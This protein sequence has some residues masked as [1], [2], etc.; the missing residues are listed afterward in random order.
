M[1][2]TLRHY[3]S[4]LSLWLPLA[5]TFQSNAVSKYHNSGTVL[6]SPQ[7]SC[8]TFSFPQTQSSEGGNPSPYQSPYCE[9]P[10]PASQEGHF[11]LSA[12]PQLIPQRTATRSTG[13]LRRQQPQRLWNSPWWGKNDISR[14]P[15]HVLPP[16]HHLNTPLQR[17]SRAWELIWGEQ[18]LNLPDVPFL[19][20][21]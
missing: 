18:A 10:K 11:R 14:S 5:L 16:S 4:C 17:L 12:L 20:Q 2:C 15:D 9:V 7:D 21:G 19:K 8:T 3:E 1:A 6:T 13:C